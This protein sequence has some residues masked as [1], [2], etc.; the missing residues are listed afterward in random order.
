MSRNQTINE[1]LLRCAINSLLINTLNPRQSERHFADDIFKC[2][3]LD[4]KV[5]TA[6]EISLKFVNKGP[7][8]NIAVQATSHYLDQ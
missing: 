7:I 8:N 1:W 6:I 2:I 3:F 5:V 4:E